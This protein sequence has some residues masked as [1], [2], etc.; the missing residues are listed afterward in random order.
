[1]WFSILFLFSL[2]MDFILMTRVYKKKNPKNPQKIHKDS[3]VNIYQIS[4]TLSSFICLSFVIF[5]YQDLCLQF[6]CGLQKNR[7]Q[8]KK[9]RERWGGRGGGGKRRRRRR[10][11]CNLY[12]GEVTSLFWLYLTSN[13]QWF[14][15][16]SK[17]RLAIGAGDTAHRVK[18]SLFN[19]QANLISISRVG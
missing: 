4:P 3:V 19:K 9:K 13:S 5:Q 12:Y 14:F 1:M 16:I 8:V 11:T 7:Q 2:L 18:L 15:H 10:K 6:S 17:S